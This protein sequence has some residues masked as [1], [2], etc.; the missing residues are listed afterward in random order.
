MIL[1]R[2]ITGLFVLGLFFSGS[3]DSRASYRIAERQF[4]FFAYLKD[5]RLPPALVAYSPTNHNPRPEK[6]RIPSP[7]SIAADLKALR[8]AFDGLVLYGYDRDVT[9]VVLA[10]AKRQGYRAILLGIWEPPSAEEVAGVAA[11]VKK[12]DKDLALAV[13]IGNEGIAFNRY[14]LDDLKLAT[15]VLRDSLGPNHFVPFCTSEPF[16]QYDQLDLQEFGDFLAPNI[17]PVFDQ[18]Q[19]GFLEAVSW[20]R[21]RART[22]A[23]TTQKPLLVKE[24]GFPH[25]GDARFTPK[26]QKAFWQSYRGG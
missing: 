11:L 13:C 5:R 16:S 14:R 18:P 24:T 25:G 4:P 9:P 23:T 17:H 10:E 12:Y 26:M 15:K 20:V 2:L 3:Q 1:T 21:E 8:P 19:L 7:D 22:L 6:H